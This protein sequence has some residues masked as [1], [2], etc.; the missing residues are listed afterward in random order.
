MVQDLVAASG[1]RGLEPLR[2]AIK[3]HLNASS[4]V[5]SV[6]AVIT[7]ALTWGM[8]LRNFKKRVLLGRR[9]HHS[10]VWKNVLLQRSV[11][12]LG[13]S[14]GLTAVGFLFTW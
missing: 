13:L 4:N 7:L 11:A 2:D 9:G 1:V 6:V 5:A 3:K 10:M 14:L 8:M 12:Y